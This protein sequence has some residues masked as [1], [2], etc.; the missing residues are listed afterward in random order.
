[1]TCSLILFGPHLHMQRQTSYFLRHS[2]RSYWIL[3]TWNYWDAI[4]ALL[5]L[6]IRNI[7]QFNAPPRKL[8]VLCLFFLVTQSYN[9]Y[10]Y[11]SYIQKEIA[12]LLIFRKNLRKPYS[13]LVP[14]YAQCLV[15]AHDNVHYLWPRLYCSH[16]LQLLRGIT[17]TPSMLKRSSLYETWT[18]TFNL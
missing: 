7:I 4:I 17:F 10:F 9:V 13:L 11:A 12:S 18:I 16:D 15:R 3:D 14:K 6:T 1:M 2:S 8:K 5:L